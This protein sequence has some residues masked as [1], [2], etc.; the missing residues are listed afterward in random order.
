MNE[1]L[2]E[3]GKNL[4]RISKQLESKELAWQ[5]RLY[6]YRKAAECVE[7]LGGMIN[8]GAVKIKDIPEDVIAGL[9]YI[10]L[11][12]EIKASDILVKA[13]EMYDISGD[14]RSAVEIAIKY[15]IHDPEDLVRRVFDRA[16][17][18]AFQL[19]DQEAEVRFSSERTKLLR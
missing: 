9:T 17:D 5:V 12:D 7:M 2:E 10:K 15:R 18:L 16:I 14:A 19:N 3:I 1:N 13:M 11:A 4:K 8:A 6:H